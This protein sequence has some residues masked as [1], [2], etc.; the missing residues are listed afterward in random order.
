M[1]LQELNQAAGDY[2]KLHWNN[3]GTS[4]FDQSINDISRSMIKAFKQ[5]HGQAFLSSINHYPDEPEK[6]MVE[7][8]GQMIY[9]FEYVIVTVYDQHLADLIREYRTKKLPFIGEWVEKVSA[10]VQKI[11]GVFLIWS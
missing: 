4:E 2:L 10:R 5:E 1:K 9:N 3:G 8:T 6:I 11:N 7:Y